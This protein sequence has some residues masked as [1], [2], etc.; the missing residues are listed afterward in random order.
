LSGNPTY[1]EWAQEVYNPDIAFEMFTDHKLSGL[2]AVAFF[3]I[4]AAA[5]F[6][7]PGK[8][9]PPANSTRQTREVP[10]SLP[11]TC[12][13][14]QPPAQAFLP[15]PPY[16]SQHSSDGFWFGS[17]KLW[18]QLRKDGIWHLQPNGP[19]AG[20]GEKVQW[21]RKGYE[22]RTDMPSKLK[23][24]GERIDSP[25]SPLSSHSNASGTT[26]HSFIMSG[27]DF[28]TLGCWQIT[29]DYAGDKLTFVVWVAR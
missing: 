12:H 1:Q 18:L 9:T 4:T 5:P 25:A 8:S 14:T 3:A 15:P 23:I 20:F 6:R 21:W 28:P 16:P 13:V 17:E 24:V 7:A 29:A 26:G 27:L 19:D 10:S 22:W 2:L 11:G